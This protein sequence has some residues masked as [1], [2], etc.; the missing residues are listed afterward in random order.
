MS[1]INEVK[2][3]IDIVEVI[4]SYIPLQKAG[5]NFK[6]L[7][8]FHA[9]KYPSFIVFPERQSWHCFGA[10]GTGG[11]VF[12]FIMK[13]E[14]VDFGQALRLLAERAGV[15]L[16]PYGM[17][18]ETEDGGRERLFQ[19]NEVAAEYYHH[20]L[21]NARVAKVASDYLVGRRISAQ[22]VRDFQL[23]FSPD[24]WEA[25]RQFLIGKGYVEKELVAVGLVIE[26]ERGGSYDRFRNRL[27][28]PIRDTKGRVIGFGARVL[29]DSLPKYV[30]SPQTAIFDKS[31][32]LYG[33]DRAKTAIRQRNLAIIV[34][35]YMDVIMAHQHGWQNVVASMG[36]SLTEKQMGGIKRLTRNITLAL[37]A[38]AAGEEATFRSVEMASEVLGEKVVPLPTWSGLVKYEGVIDA[39]IKVI[40]LPRGKDPDQVI[41]EDAS[42]WRNLV[43]EAL[44]VIDYAFEAV[45][46]KVDFKRA[47]DKSAA[48]QKLLPV[49]SEVKDPIWQAHYLQKL[50]KLLKI[51]ER[52]LEHELREFQRKQRRRRSGG[53]VRDTSPSVSSS[54]LSSSLEEYCLALLFQHPELATMG[55]ELLLEYFECS[56]NREL[57]VEWQSASDIN[58][59]R[60]TLDVSLQEHLNSLLNKTFPPAIGES[61]EGRRRDFTD[62]ALRLREE[63]LRNLVRKKEELLSLERSLGGD[64]AE[65]A[66]LEEQGI[67][68]DMQL[69]QVFKKP[70]GFG[71]RRK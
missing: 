11:D 68:A 8:P 65:L 38:D 27:M 9:E 25:L 57:F 53:T 59:L 56:E 13:K 3:K 5:Q 49:I 55:K 15:A 70:M 42:L 33:I 63:F 44:P 16:T 19:I 41:G 23:G 50:A 60:G 29:D 14:G 67:E 51:E 6:A 10:C 45:A 37:D 20:L 30:N 64:A 47:K 12:S 69:G 62:C 28:F 36:T 48:V 26:R 54:P 34:E 24:S 32:S 22:A 58:S 66:K 52:K 17:R 39:E 40:I 4:S 35:G 71:A 7:C 43:S 2:Q 31:A 18:E 1:V 61:E 46:S 21:L